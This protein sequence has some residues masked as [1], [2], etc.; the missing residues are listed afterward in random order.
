MCSAIALPE[1]AVDPRFLTNALRLANKELLWAALE[2]AFLRRSS[3]DLLVALEAN[4]VPVAPVNTIAQAL[5]DPHVRH[6]GVV[7]A[8]PAPDGSSR[9]LIGAP[10]RFVGEQQVTPVWP[11]SLGQ[12]QDAILGS[13]GAPVDRS[14]SPP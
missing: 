10:F 11:P 8:V 5:A 13:V 7:A 2:P 3:G 9:S 12:D 4:G 6:R 14:G 1:L